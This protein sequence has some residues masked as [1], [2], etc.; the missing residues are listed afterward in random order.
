MFK[1]LFNSRG[2]NNETPNIFK[3]LFLG[4]VI[5]PIIPILTL[6]YL[7]QS[8]QI[9]RELAVEEE[10]IDSASL[11]GSN[12]DRWVEKNVQVSVVMS[13]MADMRSMNPELQKPL[14]LNIKENSKAITAVRVDD[15]N[16]QAI[17]RSDNKKLKNYA[18]RQYFRQ[19][20][21]GQAIGQQVIF[22]KTQQKPLLCFTVPINDL[23]ESF[24]G[25]LSQCSTLDTISSG[26]TDLR[27]GDT[28]FAFLVDKDKKLI[29]HGGNNE[30]FL[31]R[32]EDMSGHPALLNEQSSVFSFEDEGSQVIAYKK[33]V[34][35][36]WTLVV[37]QSYS[38][39]FAKPVQAKNTALI[40]TVITA[41]ICLVIILILS[42][43][44]SKPLQQSRKETDNILG[45]A[46][47]GLFL[48]DKNYIIGEQQ[49]KNLS[50]ILQRE[51]L[52]GQNFMRYLYD[53]VTMDVSQMAQDYIDLLFS[54]RIK[55]ALVKSR[56][57]LKLIKTSV[58]NDHGQLETRYLSLTFKRVYAKKVITHLLVTAKDVTKEVVLQ[59]ELDKTKEE[60]NEQMNLLTDI[61]H[62]PHQDLMSFLE[63]ANLVLNK[64]NVVLEHPGSGQSF[65]ANKIG[66]MYRLMHKLKGD[67]SSISFSLFAKQCHEFEELLSQIKSNGTLTGNDFLP[68]T[69]A[70]E[71]LFK[72]R[73]MVDELFCR[74]ASLVKS[75]DA[76]GSFI[77]EYL[78]SWYPLQ[79]LANSIAEKNHKSVE[80]HF[81]GFKTPLPEHYRGAIRDIAVQLVRNSV[82]HGIE[83]VDEREG[84]AKI[85]EGQIVLSLKYSY[86]RGYVFTFSDDGAGID[87]AG[88]RQ[89]VVDS[90]RVSVF[91]ANDLSEKDLLKILFSSGFS[92]RDKADEDS[93]RG[94]GLS[95]VAE[96]IKALG[97]RVKVS[98]VHGKHTVFKVVLP[99]VSVVAA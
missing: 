90:G 97:G 28:G 60:K 54:D 92:T 11:I 59:Q 87:Y 99:A 44:I 85:Q 79:K 64:I 86:G 4:F 95:L 8:A 40:A 47:D 42:R 94:V 43:I 53:S 98:S 25:A 46:N 36:E 21:E 22:G 49:S 56:N 83:S 52:A 3:K 26:V 82:V 55:E 62:I 69:L 61:L 96:K 81:R 78:Q 35:L 16:G 23:Q 63:E 19:V 93:G 71:E 14:L 12:I 33:P 34:G 17:T 74:I 48:I 39:A 20:K 66:Q 45:A 31:G 76:E 57:P 9:D 24:V 7:N 65:F 77:P 51:K 29:A 73:Y 89:R 5:V 80:V 72:K 15:G 10:L 2:A 68:I 84:L 27:I 6:L 13:Q 32:L 37:Q 50:K 91:E 18:D 88:I 70:L 38:E 58:E 30:A 75:E 1:K 41:V 67:A